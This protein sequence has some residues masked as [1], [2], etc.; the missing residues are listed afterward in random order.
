VR[1][2]TRRRREASRITVRV[3]GAGWSSAAGGTEGGED[4]PGNLGMMV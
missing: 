4:L 2:W 1:R 3:W